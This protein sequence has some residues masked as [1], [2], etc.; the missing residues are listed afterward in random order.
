MI[1]PAWGRASYLFNAGITGIDQA[2]A[3][4]IIGA[5]PRKEAAVLNARLRKRWRQTGLPVARIGAPADL[6]YTCTDLGASLS[7]LA[8]IEAGK[9]DFA[10][11]LQAAKHPLVIVGHSALKGSDAQAVLAAAARLSQREG[12]NGLA[13]LHH[14]ASRVGALDL[15]CVPS[16]G[17]LDARAMSKANAVDVLFLLG[18]D[19]ID[20]DLGAFVVYIG[21]HGDRGAHR[22]DVILPAAAYTEKSG[23]YV[24]TEGRVQRGY[25][26]SFPPGD[27]R[28]DWAIL[29]ALSEQLGAGHQLPFNSLNELRAF[30]FKD[31]PALAELD[32]VHA[33]SAAGIDALIAHKGSFAAQPLEPLFAD[34]YMTNPI[35]RA[36]AIMAECSALASGHVAMAAE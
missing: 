28:E 17:G 31:Y 13:V 33:H 35:A 30:L 34:F 18:A 2:D 7:A 21:S 32:H 26:A 16:Q 25:R 15:H 19:E 36:S 27:A 10:A 29:R 11:V 24:N 8:D 6:T 12:W 22:A 4:L 3:V 14:A 9:G 23:L 1:D 5:N 20:V